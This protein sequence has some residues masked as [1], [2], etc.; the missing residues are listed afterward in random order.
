MDKKLVIAYLG[1]G[2]AILQ[3]HLPYSRNM[4]N[5]IIKYVY[6]RHED[7]ILDPEIE[8]DYPDLYITEDIEEIKNDP[9]VNLV[10]IG[11][12][13][14]THYPYAMMFLELGK[15]V[16][17]EKPISHSKKEAE[18]I[19]AYA[20]E[21]GLIADVNQNRRFDGDFLT[22]KSVLEKGVLGDVLELESH[23]DYYRPNRDS[24]K[25]MY[26]YGMGVHTI[27]QM[28]SLN[29]KPDRVVYDVRSMHNPGGCDD[30]FDIDFFYGRKKVTVKTSYYVKI[31]S[32]RFIVHGTKGSL[33]LP[34][35]GHISEGG[36]SAEVFGDLSY[37]D[38]NGVEH[39]EKVKMLD[40]NYG[41]LYE[42]LFREIFDG[43]DKYIKDEELLMVLDI[44]KEAVDCALAQQ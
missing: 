24:S 2:R 15:N 31:S 29:G 25:P 16:L 43:Q 6:R 44:M 40:S 20:K 11:T 34:Q 9:E 30:Y 1:F 42:N 3:Y 13:D 12:P 36:Q 35:V 5:V 37:F 39:N 22:L 38:E 26:V 10:V 14:A 28:I 32:P 41:L 7:R 23:Y 21:K 18:E 27:D 4:E 8:N 19:L 33:I 17:I